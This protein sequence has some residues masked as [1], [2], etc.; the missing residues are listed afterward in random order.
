MIAATSLVRCKDALRYN[1]TIM[2]R[3]PR[4]DA[5]P[6][7]VLGRTSPTSSPLAV[8]SASPRAPTTSASMISDP[9]PGTSGSPPSAKKQKTIHFPTPSRPRGP[10]Q[11]QLT[12]FAPATPARRKP[13]GTP[14]SS[15]SKKKGTN[16]SILNFFKPTPNGKKADGT[17]DEL[18]IQHGGYGLDVSDPED[19]GYGDGV[20]ELL[21][22]RG[23]ESGEG[24]G[25]ERWRSTTGE[26]ELAENLTIDLTANDMGEDK[27][28]E[29]STPPPPGEIETS[30]LDTLQ[31]KPK[32]P[33]PKFDPATL[34]LSLSSSMLFGKKPAPPSREVEPSDCDFLAVGKPVGAKV[35]TKGCTGMT[36]ALLDRRLGTIALDDIEDPSQPVA[37]RK[38]AVDQCSQDDI[39]ATPHGNAMDVDC[40]TGDDKEGTNRD[41]A[42]FDDVEDFPDDEMGF[43]EREGTF[44]FDPAVRGI[45]G[46]FEEF[47]GDWGDMDVVMKPPEGSIEETSPAMAQ[48]EAPEC[49]M[50]QVKLGGLSEQ[51][52][53]SH[54]NACIDGKPIPLPKATAAPSASG[55]HSFTKPP[56]SRTSNPHAPLQTIT[57]KPSAFSRI[58]STNTEAQAWEAAAREEAGSRGKRAAERSCPFYKILFD[59]PITVDAFRYGKVLGC[60]AYFLSH[61]H[62]DHY[63]GLT[64]K[65][66]HGPIYCSRVTANL[67][68]T[69]LRVDPKWVHELPWEEWYEVP[70]GGGA[71]V[72]GL[73]A[74]H[75]PGS[76][77]FLFEK[78]SEGK[79]YR[80]LHCGDFRAD[81]K[82]LNHPL[83]RPGKD[84]KRRLDVVYLD[85]TYL[86]PKYAFPTQ[87]NVINVCGEMCVSLNKQKPPPTVKK[88]GKAV[89]KPT[90]GRLLVVVGTYSIGKERIAI[91]TPRFLRLPGYH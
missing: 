15:S 77:L 89:G 35:G 21:M 86:N 29:Q 10:R 42:G 76:M 22:Y 63:A 11:T 85:T 1:P 91:G 52:V 57:R 71:R 14:K 17:S 24:E 62:S 2:F 68:R 70:E 51:E 47:D 16:V 82:H 40:N 8:S 37:E 83:L 26:L 59:G 7:A 69:R 78:G 90:E 80:V 81:P 44:G 28:E 55:Y 4:P 74:N 25:E 38:L 23:G 58:M 41:F 79:K 12:A 36:S 53:N 31:A 48:D 56:T 46:G 66:D 54:V 43:E 9:A 6:A 32:A 65:W 73:D 87:K 13:A 72:K 75:C 27:M 3:K 67:V 34:N 84:G 33:G 19:E 45:E 39:E 30:T 64:S 18:F 88:E 20:E 60:N 49:P 61:F 5:P 50:C